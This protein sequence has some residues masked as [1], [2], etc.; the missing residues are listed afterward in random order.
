MFNLLI[1]PAGFTA[2]E[3]ARVRGILE[4]TGFGAAYLPGASSRPGNQEEQWIAEILTQPHDGELAQEMRAW[5]LDVSPVDDDRPFFFYQNRLEDAPRA[6]WSSTPGHLFGNG[7]GILLKVLVAALVMT[8]LC[9]GGPLVVDML[10]LGGSFRGATS[11]VGY[12]CMLGFGYMFIELGTIQRVMPY[13]GSPTHALTS[14]LL[15]LLLTGALGSTFAG[16]KV[17]SMQLLFVALVGYAGML[18]L[19]WPSIADA[20]AVFTPGLRALVASTVLA[21]LGFL[22]G[23]PFPSGLAAVRERNAERIPW[24]W[25]VNG[26][27]SVLGSVLS[28]IG[29]MHFGIRMLLA[30]GVLSYLVAAVLWKKVA[31]E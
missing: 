31:P 29:A 3:L 12:V 13:L 1:K 11:D 14:V 28:T 20:T 22:M 9:V 2:A 21:P 10:T 23:T 5:P 26:A 19:A 24:L 17:V 25:G 6:L 7:L 15:V 4:E 30:A 16:R 27:T 18:L 8:L